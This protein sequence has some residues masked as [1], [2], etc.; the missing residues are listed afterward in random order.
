[1]QPHLLVL[2]L[3]AFA[4]PALAAEPATTTAQAA[5]PAAAPT[6]TA[7]GPAPLR[8]LGQLPWGRVEL[9]VLRTIGGCGV[10]TVKEGGRTYYVP[11]PGTQRIPLPARYGPRQP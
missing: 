7:G 8:R 1:M 11:T 5:C 2:S 4:A 6:P 9:A 3:I 10:A